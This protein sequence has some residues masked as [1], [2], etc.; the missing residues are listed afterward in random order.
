VK[1]RFGSTGVQAPVIGQ[2]TWNLERAERS[3]AVH[4]LRRGIDLGLSHIDTAEMYGAGA[5]EEI[6]GEA[7]EGRRDEV[8]LVSKVLPSNAS[9]VGVKRACEHSLRRLRTD[10]IDVY[11]LHW[12]SD[13]PLQETI[14]AF[15]ELVRDGK[16]RAWG[17]SNFD[18]DQLE[19]AIV[20]AGPGRVACN[21]V[22]YHLGARSV[23]RELGDAC[24]RHDVALVG[25]SPFGSGNFV[26]PRSSGGRVLATI[27][28]AHEASARQVALAFLTRLPA[29]FT[30]PKAVSVTH[31]ED[32]SAASRIE[33][34]ESQVAAID[35]AFPI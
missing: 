7:I 29:T 31:L 15:E 13:H 18:R 28:Q 33:L 35:A 1:R 17:V 5:V 10:W 30:I 34:S 21:Q 3:E 9:A 2:G 12:P 26:A 32:N 16:I 11:L 4:A 8:F 23:E 25:Y 22:L 27:A 24:V 19:Q 14:G 6:V 20:A